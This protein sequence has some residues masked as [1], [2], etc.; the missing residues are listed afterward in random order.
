[1]STY[2][3]TLKYMGATLTTG[4]QDHDVAL[5]AANDLFKAYSKRKSPCK[6]SIETVEK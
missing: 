2:I 3:V 5:K 6:V 1:M 4:F